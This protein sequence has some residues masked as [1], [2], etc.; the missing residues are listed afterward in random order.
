[1]AGRKPMTEK[2]VTVR[3][4]KCYVEAYPRYYGIITLWL[5]NKEILDISEIKGME[6]L[7]NLEILSLR[8]NQI[9]EIK[10]LD[11]LSNLKE[12]YLSGNQIEKIK[13]LETLINLAL[14]YLSENRIKTDYWTGDAY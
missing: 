11:H 2:F 3:G 14:L 5:T 6:K 8:L 7:K 4:E 13:G 9:K 10:G 12:L 1:M